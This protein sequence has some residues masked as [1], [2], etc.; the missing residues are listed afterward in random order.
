[1]YVKDTIPFTVLEDLE[2]ESGMEVLWAKMRPT[3][4]PRGVSSIITGLVYHPPKAVNSA[5]LDY[6]TRC[7]VNIESRYP[8]CG[9]V[10]L[11]DLNQLNDARL[12]SNFNLKQIV[13][14]PI[15]GRNTR[16][17]VLTNLKTYYNPPIGRPAFGHTSHK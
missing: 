16:D 11:G 8:N 7:L 9:I 5:M 13:H 4:L 6:L 10:V 12:K 14:F 1:M 3:R 2:D 15:R 17:K